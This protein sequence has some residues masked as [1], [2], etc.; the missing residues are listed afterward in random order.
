[1]NDPQ[2]EGH[3]ASHIERRKFLAALGGAA[4]AWPLAALAQQPAMPVI[5]FLYQG[6]SGSPVLEPRLAAFRAGLREAGYIEKQ[7]IIIEYRL[8]DTADRLPGLAAELV[9]LNV[10]LIVASG[11]EATAAAQQASRTVPIVM[12]SSSD[13]V[14]T[15]LVASLARPG[16]NTTGMSLASSDIAGK[17]LELLR[18]IVNDVSGVVVFWKPDDPPAALSLKET[19]AAAATLGMTLTPIEVRRSADFEHA[20][21]LAA[22]AQARGIVI[23]PAPLLTLHIGQ[24]ADFALQQRLPSIAHSTEFPKAG[25]L[26]SY[27][28]SFI[29]SFRRCA[30]YVGKILGGVKPADLPVQQPVRFELALNLKTAKALGLEVP[31]TLLA[32]ADEVIE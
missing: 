25:G 32:R 20:F 15:G 1:M 21:A 13:P 22:Q 16:G 8:A 12:T 2:P 9:A 14:G 5:G 7:N 6:P 30:A 17:R 29:D 26:I 11:S 31:P 10:Q 24:I 4:A 23:L 19:Q 28:P 27:G 18:E 3:M